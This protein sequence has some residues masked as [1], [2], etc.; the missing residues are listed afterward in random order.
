MIA[1]EYLESQELNFLL[2]PI[3]LANLRFELILLA[4]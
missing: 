3:L 1:Y 4:N 2:F